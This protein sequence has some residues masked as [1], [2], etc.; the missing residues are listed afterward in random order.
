MLILRIAKDIIRS[1]Y[2]HFFS[3]LAL[4]NGSQRRYPQYGQFRHISL[5]LS[6]AT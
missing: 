4:Y 6:T 3:T 1:R 5:T 2:V